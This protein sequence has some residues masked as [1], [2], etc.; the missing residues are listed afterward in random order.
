[1]IWRGSWIRKAPVITESSSCVVAATR[2]AENTKLLSALLIE[3]AVKRR[4]I[5]IVSGTPHGSG[6][7]L[8]R[9]RPS[10]GPLTYV[11]GEL[12]GRYDRGENHLTICSAISK[13]IY[14]RERDA[15]EIERKNI[16]GRSL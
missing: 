6:P 9:R 14:C 3:E 5:Y 15:D 8:G 4:N 11:I 10:G 12:C 2:V 16:K 1:M 7:L 13:L